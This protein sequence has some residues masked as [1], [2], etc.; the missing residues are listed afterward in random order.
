MPTLVEVAREYADRGVRYF[1][2]NLQEEPAKVRSYLKEAKLQLAVPLD[3]DGAVARKYGVQGIPTMVIVDKDG[4]VAKV[5]VGS[6]PRLKAEL[7]RVLDELLAAKRPAPKSRLRC[8]FRR[9]RL[10]PRRRWWI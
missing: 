8:R 6:S 1:A 2:V 10:K 5:H 4:V 3:K 7:T 9:A